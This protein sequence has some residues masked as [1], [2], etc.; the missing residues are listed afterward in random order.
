[1]KN[2]LTILASLILSLQFVSLV[3]KAEDANAISVKSEID[4]M[5]NAD[6]APAER[7]PASESR[8]I[9]IEAKAANRVVRN[10]IKMNPLKTDDDLEFK[11]DNSR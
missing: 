11:K 9:Y 1:M 6:S 2:K 4:Q 10:P 7:S 3:A 5:L 8:T